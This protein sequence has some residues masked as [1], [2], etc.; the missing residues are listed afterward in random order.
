M[1]DKRLAREIKQYSWLLYILIGLS[2]AGGLSAIVQ[3]WYLTNVINGVFLTGLRLVEI[4]HWMIILLFF[5]FIR[6]VIVWLLEFVGHRLAAG[7][8]Q[9]LRRRLL[10]KIFS[11]GP[12][13][14]GP[15]RTGELVTLLSQGIEQLEVYFSRYLPQLC[16]A[17]LIPL[18]ILTV[19]V[20]R[21]P[22][23]AG[24]L[25]ATAP[26][27]PVFMVLIGKRAQQKAA[28]QWGVLSRVSAHLLDVLEGLATLKLFGR[29]KEQVKVVDR[30]SREFSE[31]T[32][33]VLRIAFLS[34]LVL[35]LVATISTAL[36]A[37]G[38]G[39]RLLY[40]QI[41]FREALFV[42]LLTP[43]FYLPLRQLGSHFHS[44]LTAVSAADRIFSLLNQEHPPAQFGKEQF[45][46]PKELNVELENVSF[47]Y[48]GRMIPALENV[49]VSVRSGERIAIVGPSG[50]GKS[51]LIHLLLGFI[52]PQRGVI[53]VNGRVLQELS[54]NQWLQAVAV[55][56]QSPHLFHCSVADNIRMGNSTASLA[57][58]MKAAEAAGAHE[59]IRQLPDGYETLLGDGGYSLSGG[60]RQRLAIAR[61]FLKNAPLLILDEA[62]SG[63][64]PVNEQWLERSL[65]DLMRDRTVLI[66]AHRLST[67]SRADRILVM[68]QGQVEESGN[69][70]ELMERRQ[71]YYQM[72][73]AFRGTK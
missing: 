22:V 23:T 7:I 21:D 13:S 28:E 25:L 46:F 73:T 39:L 59:F 18:S 17:V 29:S 11:M 71:S 6:A 14:G 58:V 49:S 55:V 48:P 30:M 31:I 54:L 62:S 32:L 9:E 35:E 44:G 53:R 65:T 4:R 8:K 56:P 20:V 37:V 2:L 15:E 34:A 38:I 69:H 19:I 66:I 36:V 63:L 52:I 5:I 68:Q 72:V 1:I 33:G 27:I 10:D 51:T 26:L 60:Q 3:A 16:I 57:A 47:S 24:I 42:L 40:S 43:D 70:Q 12:V 61:A 45:P 67:V 50:A 41:Q 64:D